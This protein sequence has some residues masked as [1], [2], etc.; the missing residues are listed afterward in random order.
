MDGS[1]NV[2]LWDHDDVSADDLLGSVTI[3]EDEQGGG[4]LSKLAH[5]EEGRS[6]YYVQYH[7]D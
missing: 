4:S 6:Y 3:S 5:S 1:Q 7:V 2:F